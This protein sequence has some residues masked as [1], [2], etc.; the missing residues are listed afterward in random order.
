MKG[1]I[2]TT[3]KKTYQE[4]LFALVDDE[5]YEMLSKISWHAIKSKSG[6]IVYAAH[7]TKNNQR[8]YMHEMIIGIG[9]S[10]IIIDHIDGDGLH[11]YRSNLR[12]VTYKQNSQ[13][14]HFNK[15]NK[16]SCEEVNEFIKPV[17]NLEI[18]RMEK[19]MREDRRSEEEIEAALKDI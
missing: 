19:L 3:R 9:G 6:K 1:I 15:P 16:Y 13:N 2:L 12:H 18:Q 4:R 5:D 17:F 10:G 7:L 11:N 8:V 14:L